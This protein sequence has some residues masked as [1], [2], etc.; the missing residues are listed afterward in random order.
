MTQTTIN[1]NQRPSPLSAPHVIAGFRYQILQS[2]I[3]LLGLQQEEKLLLEVSEDFSVVSTDAVTDVQVKNSQAVAGPR[4]F[5]LQSSDV[6]AVI[7]R[8]WQASEEAPE[9]KRRLVFLARGGAATERDYPFPDG[10]SGLVYW[11]SAA[12]DADTTPLRSALGALFSEQPL[13]R[14]L[15]SNP[16][17]SDLRNRL[18]RRVSWQL[19]EKPADSLVLQ[20]RDQISNFYYSKNLPVIAADQAVNSLITLVFEVAS[21]PSY[22][23]RVLDIIAVQRTLEEAAGNSL[24]AQAMA[25]AISISVQPPEVIFVNELERLPLFLTSRTATVATLSEQTRGLPLVWL[26][27]AHGVGKSTLARIIAQIFG[28]RWLVLDLR[29][30][31]KDAVASVAA[32]RELLR[33]AN[34]GIPLDGIIIDDFSFE[35]A[36]A[37]RSRLAALVQTSSSR[38]A[39]VIVTSRQAPSPAHLLE[40]GS[41]SASVVQAPYF[42]EDEI[43]ELVRMAPSPEPDM[44]RAWSVMLFLTTGGGQPVL[45]AAKVASNRERG[46]PKA[47]L[48]EDIGS[49]SEAMRLTRDEAK[50][51]LLRDLQELDDA[52][53]LEAGQ[54]LRRIACVFDRTE[55][56]LICMLAH[57]SPALSST[58]ETLAVLRGSWLEILP[59]GDLRISP[60]LADL[61]LD[62]PPAEAKGWRRMAAE[63]WISIGSLNER[64]LPLCF[65][66]AFLGEHSPVLLKLCGIFQTMPKE[67]LRG[68]APLLSPVTAL[69]TDRPIY[70]AEPIVAVYLRLLQFQVADAVE[71]SEAAGRIA[72]RLIIE[73]NKLNDVPKALLMTAAAS[74]VLMAGSASLS[75]SLRLS[76]AVHLRASWP[77]TEKLSDGDITEP[78]S[79]LPPQFSAEMDL[80]DF[81]F[82]TVVQHTRGSQD[83]LDAF[84]ALDG[85]SPNIRN[86]F[87]DAISA[88]FSGPSVLVNSG[89]SKDQLSD[90]D[91]SVALGCYDQIAAILSSWGRPDFEAEAACARSVILDEG[92]GRAVDAI[93]AIDDAT[94]KFGH[95]PS[96]I[97]QK[98]KV[99][100][101]AGRDLD[102][103]E[104]LLTIEDQVGLDD[105]LE[106]VLALRDGGVSAAKATKYDDAVRLFDKARNAIGSRA[107][108]TPLVSALLVEKALALWRGDN[109]KDAL[110]AAAD[111][112][113][114]VEALPMDQS[115]Q[116]ERSH[117]FARAI[118][119]LFFGEASFGGDG[120]TP[121]FTFGQASTLELSST[122]L[123]GVKLQTMADSWRVLAAVEAYLGTDLGI[124]ARSMA[125]QTG[126]LIAITELYIRRL[127]YFSSLR[128]GDAKQT[129]LAALDLANATMAIKYCI[130]DDSGIKRV[131][132]ARLVIGDDGVLTDCQFP[133]GSV[134]GLEQES[135]AS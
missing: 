84:R 50:R 57:G 28:G 119:G 4:T 133:V 81:L 85:L 42:T 83:A 59:R 10:S 27:G 12:I 98:S 135:V 111:A 9:S 66:N 71:Q 124:D 75:P 106:R 7:G 35:A 118:V 18:L 26:H 105:P 17:D 96:L 87:V 89:W 120:A 91:M 127:R 95:L 3:A 115:R 25:G 123:L 24:V 131:E 61:T 122:A 110:I 73:I 38:G 23:D 86:R 47:A 77:L 108:L 94:T 49:T 67:Q 22:S 29:P 56:G 100:G 33:E 103:A 114:A 99:L 125:K 72:E 82:T 80:A 107:N 121:P 54:L 65:W 52:R 51:S 36:D 60:L 34:T 2:V 88:I 76:Y 79:L 19:D 78:R 90:R 32:W 102:A 1:A 117:Q 109:K 6:R 41:G 132:A 8:F 116:S 68:A 14:W 74:I 31:Q 62:V 104:L 39:R 16:T 11:K 13:G 64:T 69:V 101:H 55:D 126:P 48:T 45:V 97:R 5:S 92:L 113:E 44:V 30:V 15:A 20:A 53:S 58:S 40:F 134:S 70:D 43:A 130:T 129:E 112:L 63:Y 46:W 93:A 128:S 37:L 21:R